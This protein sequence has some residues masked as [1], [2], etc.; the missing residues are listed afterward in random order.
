[1]IFWDDRVMAK[2]YRPVPRDQGFLLPPDLRDWLPAGHPVWLVI[3]MVDRHLDSSAV[4]ALRRTG[5]A[6]AAG[7]DP[8][9]L[10][11]L[12]V[13]AYANRVTSSRRIEGLCRTDIA[14]KVICAGQVPD[15]VTIPRFRAG[16]GH[17]APP[18]PRPALLFPPPPGIHPLRP[19]PLD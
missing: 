7:Y 2:G 14:F 6:G 3:E 9:M 16:L 1:M 18:L 17:A 12:L 5:A 15:H 19:A 10:T 4:H 11:A 8:D 13:W